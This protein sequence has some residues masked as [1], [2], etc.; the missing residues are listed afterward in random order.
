MKYYLC[1][2]RYMEMLKIYQTS[3]KHY[4]KSYLTIVIPEA[5]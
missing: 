4:E 1:D 3:E 5:Y 2:E